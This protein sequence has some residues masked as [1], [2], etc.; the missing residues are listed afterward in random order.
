M[1]T[2]IRHSPATTAV[3]L[4]LLKSKDGWYETGEIYDSECV[5]VLLGHYENGAAG[6]SARRQPNAPNGVLI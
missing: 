6:N 1:V 2:N 4:A 3:S 5:V